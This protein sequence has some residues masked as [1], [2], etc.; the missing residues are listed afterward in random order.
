MTLQSSFTVFISMLQV[1][2]LEAA[3]ISNSPGGAV[4]HLIEAR[5]SSSRMP[6]KSCSPAMNF[7]NTVT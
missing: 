3:N 1:C 4:P 2:N 5:Y 7:V 6:S